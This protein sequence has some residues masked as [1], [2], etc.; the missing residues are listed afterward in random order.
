[1]HM[2]ADLCVALFYC[3]IEGSS[4]D[5]GWCF[6]YQAGVWDGWVN[7]SKSPKVRVQ[8]SHA[9]FVH[10]LAMPVGSGLSPSAFTSLEADIADVEP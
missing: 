9:H 7:T 8:L 3:H 2:C 1:M 5:W 6:Q 10:Q 4:S